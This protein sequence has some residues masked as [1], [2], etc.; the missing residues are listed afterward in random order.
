MMNVCV[1]S[2]LPSLSTVRTQLTETEIT[3]QICGSPENTLKLVVSSKACMLA[4]R[5]DGYAGALVWRRHIIH[6]VS[7]VN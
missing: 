5:C 7:K 1:A 2:T 3:S 4:T 6:S